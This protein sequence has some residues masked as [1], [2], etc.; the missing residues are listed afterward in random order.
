MYGEAPLWF[1]GYNEFMN[2]R[3]VKIQIGVFIALLVVLAL[4]WTLSGR[5]ST[6]LFILAAV[7]GIPNPWWVALA[8]KLSKKNK[9]Q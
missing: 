3:H 4:A 2:P 6:W 5:Q 9:G 8:N 7:I 1:V